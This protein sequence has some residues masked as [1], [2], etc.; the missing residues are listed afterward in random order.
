[1]R[2]LAQQNENR[3]A[4]L[5]VTMKLFTAATVCIIP[6]RISSQIKTTLVIALC[7]MSVPLHK[8]V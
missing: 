3:N 4:E 1:M 2:C 7:L 6:K 5:L 8:N